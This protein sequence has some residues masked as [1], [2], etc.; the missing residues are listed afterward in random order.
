MAEVKY[1][2]LHEII[3]AH[4]QRHGYERYLL[5]NRFLF[6]PAGF[7]ATWISIRAGLTSEAASWISGFVALSGFVCLMGASLRLLEAGIG[8]LLL[9]NLFDCIDGDIARSMK[10]QNPYGWFLDSLMGWADMGF[11]GVV[12]IMAYRHPNLLIWPDLL[13]KGAILWLAVGGLSSFLSIY[14]AYVENVFDVLLREPWNKLAVNTQASA[15]KSGA[16]GGGNYSLSVNTGRIIVH[17]LRVR[18]THYILLV[19][20]FVVK[21]ID[22]YLLFYFFYYFLHAVFLMTIY[23]NRGL[24]V[25][26]SL[27]K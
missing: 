3:E 18:E 14:A 17:N 6:R 22:I 2:T 5:L 20:A 7:F 15:D 10:T 19:I 13:N 25:K 26:K 27:M 16:A 12:G 9:F 23:C 1:P 11:W 8:L 24:K 21:S 4:S